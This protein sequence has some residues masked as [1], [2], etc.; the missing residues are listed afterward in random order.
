MGQ[1]IKYN[2]KGN[3]FPQSNFFARFDSFC[4]RCQEIRIRIL[5]PFMSNWVFFLF[6]MVG[7]HFVEY[8]S[9]CNFLFQS[10]HLKLH[11]MYFSCLQFSTLLSEIQCQM[12]ACACVRLPVKESVIYFQKSLLYNIGSN[13]LQKI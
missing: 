4:L 13:V 1:N 10:T 3:Y 9:Y 11:E 7:F 12:S 6:S 2:K 8:S 5:A